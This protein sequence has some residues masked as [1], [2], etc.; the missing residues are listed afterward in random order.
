[1]QK[2]LESRIE[3]VH[4][5]LEQNKK[6][7]QTTYDKQADIILAD[8]PV[9]SLDPVTSLEIMDELKMINENMGKTVIVNI[10]SVELAKKFSKRIIA[11]QDGKLVFDGK[12]E[13]LTNE[14]LTM[15][16]KGDSFL[17]GS[18]GGQ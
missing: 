1:M 12:P 10:H 5:I 7:W 16:Y 9:S 18:E 13:S 14:V 17:K 8:E 4:K 2:I 3:Q 6:E 11:L 15:I